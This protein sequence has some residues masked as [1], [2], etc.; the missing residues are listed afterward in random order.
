MT[1]RSGIRGIAMFVLM[2]VPVITIV[3]FVASGEPV[4]KPA[5]RAERY[6]PDNVIAISQYM[7]TIARG[8]ERHA[9]KDPTAAID[10]FRKAV[11]LQPKMALA[12]YLLVEA[13]LQSN[14]MGEA[15]ASLVLALDA[16]DSTKNP[17]LRSRVLFLAADLLERQKQW[18]K[19]KAAWQAYAEHVGKY[20]DAGHP[21]SSAE[22][23]KA[24][25]RVMD[26]EKAYAAVR[27]RIAAEKDGGAKS[28]APK[29]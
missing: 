4:K 7:E 2:A 11:Q 25:Q 9:A 14:N 18:E 29:K 16:E 20:A 27:D 21:Q 10:A 13:Y 28:P 26:T 5:S 24:I 17:A 3:P 12:H 15:E 19:A 8:T 1:R 23:L 6:D 22:R